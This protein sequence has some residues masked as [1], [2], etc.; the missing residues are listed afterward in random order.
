MLVGVRVQ[1][2]AALLGRG[3]SG[4]NVAPTQWVPGG[5]LGAACDLN[6][7]STGPT[8]AAKPTL[9]GNEAGKSRPAPGQQAEAAQPRADRVREAEPLRPGGR[10]Q[11]ATARMPLPAAG[12]RRSATAG[13]GQR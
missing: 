2:S 1:G 10:R 7:T 12:R 13:Q 9:S 11:A 5:G 3:A 4:V 8:L 6:R